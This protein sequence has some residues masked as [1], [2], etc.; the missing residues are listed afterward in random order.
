M[1]KLYLDLAIAFFFLVALVLVSR[2]R[3]Q[4][5]QKNWTTYGLLAAGLCILALMSVYTAIHNQLV[6][7]K[8]IATSTMAVAELI[9]LLMLVSGLVLVTSAMSK[10]LPIFN[11][12]PEKNESLI[13]KFSQL[14]RREQLYSM[15]SSI[16]E[17]LRMSLEII[18][19]NLQISTGTV[20]LI[21]P[22]KNKAKLA[23][24]IGTLD[25]LAN[26]SERFILNQSWLKQLSVSKL[27]PANVSFSEI[28]PGAS[29][30]C[31]CFPVKASEQ[32]QFLYLLW[33]KDTL[34]AETFDRN[35]LAGIAGC[36]K[37]KLHS[38]RLVLRNDFN[39]MCRD[40]ANSMK[41]K[42]AS[43]ESINERLVSAKTELQ[44]RMP[45]D[46]ISLSL[47]NVGKSLRRIS[48]GPSGTILNEVD[49]QIG[50]GK[51]Y[52]NQVNKEQKPLLVSDTSRIRSADFSEFLLISDIKSLIAIPLGGAGQSRGV[53]TVGAIRPGIY[54]KIEKEIVT[55]VSAI[56]ES[57]LHEMN[58]KEQAAG[59]G[60]REK[61]L[62]G[63]AIEITHCDSPTALCRRAVS[64]IKK[65]L[66][67]PIIRVSTI[68]AEAKFLN[69][70]VLVNECKSEV[71]TPENG[72]L[73]LSLLRWH[74]AAQEIGHT[75]SVNC[76]AGEKGMADI[77]LMQVF[78]AGVKR[79]VIVPI[80]Y[81]DKILGLFSLADDKVIA[82][83]SL[84][85]ANL[86][87]VETI[88]ALTAVAI[89]AFARSKSVLSEF[90]TAARGEIIEHGQRR[91][92]RLQLRSSLTS[93]IGSL[94]MIRSGDTSDETKRAKFLTIIDKSARKMNELLTE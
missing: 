66:D 38:E 94:E 19:D 36:I 42:S 3:E 49:A 25:N 55:S 23:A 40:L 4:I 83:S 68:D 54:R 88:A 92:M 73:I 1:D 6:E 52:L 51:S 33:A 16:G 21:S 93:I 24:S 89:D 61:L 56:F 75:V 37:A 76:D 65:V 22:S 67:C 72:H 79:A 31:Y 82:A 8:I 17:F 74:K 59:M 78:A 28:H 60:E 13:I 85:E 86:R 46:F 34:G 80:K 12:K 64:T 62:R 20:Y 35:I 14:K 41:T 77:E 18:S 2:T 63:F 84:T 27:T 30:N 58:L 9:R 87:F 11:N 53:L 48:I 50:S 70:Q 47:M 57:I 7:Q 45:I 29:G 10:W 90:A 15:P 26:I 32:L 81:S 91:G 44:T 71:K 43:G 5:G 39:N 69:S